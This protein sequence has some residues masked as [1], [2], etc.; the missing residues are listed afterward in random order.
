[1]QPG[2]LGLDEHVFYVYRAIHQFV[3]AAVTVVFRREIQPRG[4]VGLRVCVYYEHFFL[5]CRQRCRQVDCSG[6]FSHPA[7]LV[8]YRDYFSHIVQ[9]Y[10]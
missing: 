4:G 1:M 9:K 10:E 7:L 3:Q 8:G 6:G 5:K 2:H